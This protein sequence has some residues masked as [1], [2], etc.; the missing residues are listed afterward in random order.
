M[1]SIIVPSYNEEQMIPITEQTISKLM[2]QE[3]IPY[4]LMFVNDG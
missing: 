1:L 4:E 2:E 3:N